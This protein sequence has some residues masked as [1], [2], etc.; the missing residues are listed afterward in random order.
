VTRTLICRDWMTRELPAIGQAGQVPGEVWY[1]LVSLA[2]LAEPRDLWL[3]VYWRHDV[4]GW[5]SG[6]WRETWDF[7]ATFVPA[8]PLHLRVDRRHRD[9]RALRRWQATLHPDDRRR[10]VGYQRERTTQVTYP[11]AAVSWRSGWRGR[12]GRVRARRQ[13]R[14]AGVYSPRPGTR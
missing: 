8:L 1:P 6:G 2:L 7:Y 10:Q 9:T 3:G 14:R 4:R 12:P 5:A 11:P 13:W